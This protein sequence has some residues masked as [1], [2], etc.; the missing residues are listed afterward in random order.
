MSLNEVPNLETSLRFSIEKER[1]VPNSSRFCELNFFFNGKFV[2]SVISFLFLL[3]FEKIA[4]KTVLQ[5]LLAL[6]VCQIYKRDT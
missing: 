5:G 1:I 4:E 2:N 6:S 3:I